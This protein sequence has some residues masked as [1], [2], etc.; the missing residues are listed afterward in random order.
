M[1]NFSEAAY[2]AYPIGVPYQGKYKEI[3]N[4]D[5][6]AFGGAGNVNPRVKMSRK[7]ECDERQDSISIK[8]PALG[9]CV[10][11]Y[12][13]AVEKVVDN[14]TAKNKTKA[15]GK[16]TNLKEVLEKKVNEK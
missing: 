9:M 1:C 8:V 11:S 3:F 16:K 12:S 14:K 2:D 6:E 4:S 13:K 7:T 15:V 10:F 5:A